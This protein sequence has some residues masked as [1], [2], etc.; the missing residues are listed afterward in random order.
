MMMNAY[1]KIYVEDASHNLGV[2]VDCAVNTLGIPIEQFWDSFLACSVSA[3]FSRGSVDVL[4]GHSG[5]ELALMVLRE[6]GRVIDRCDDRVSISSKEYWGGV[7]MALYQWRTGLS[8]R[9]LND[10]GL[11]ISVVIPM[12][13]P[14]HE[15]DITVFEEAADEIIRYGKNDNSWLKR[16]RTLNGYTQAE[17]SVRSGVPLRLIRAYEQEKIDLDKAEYRTVCALKSALNIWDLTP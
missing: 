4:V 8:F 10:R 7:T 16:G 12:F 3:R 11:R 9:E 17:L 5:I 15:A 6:T 14:F 13:Y 1:D 2:M